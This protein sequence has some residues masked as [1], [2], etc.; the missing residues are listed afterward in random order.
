[1]DNAALSRMNQGVGDLE[2]NLDRLADRQRSVLLDPLPE[3]GPLNIFKSD[4]MIAAVVADRV[5]ARDILVVE[6]CGG[7]PFLIEPLH[8]LGV[9]RLFGREDLQ[10]NLPIKPLIERPENRPHATDTDRFFDQESIDPLAQSRKRLNG[11]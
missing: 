1:M 10:R 5:N 11:G 4:V 2:R 8:D 6:A 7:A 9:V 3:R